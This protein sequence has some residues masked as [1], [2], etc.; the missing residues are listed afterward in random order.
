[1]PLPYVQDEVPDQEAAGI[2]SCFG[3][4][5]GRGSLDTPGTTQSPA[6]S[7]LSSASPSEGALS[8]YCRRQ[9]RS[10][11]VDSGADVSVFPATP[12][13][14]RKAPTVNLLAANGSSIRTY[15]K[16]SIALSFPGLRVVHVF[17]LAAVRRPILGTDFFRAQDL[18]ID[19]T[20]RRLFR[21]AEC[22][23]AAVEVRARPAQFAGGLCGLRRPP[24]STCSP[25]SSPSRTFSP[26]T[27][28]SASSLRVAVQ[29]LFA[30]FPAV[31]SAPVYDSTP[32]KHGIFHTVPTS[33][34]PVYALSLIHI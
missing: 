11:L 22:S 16:K 19:I 7:T 14:R 31:T 13:Q 27:P 30:E 9:R 4:R 12:A 5:Q 15:G 25:S 24:T 6:I 32:P 33:G 34:P 26:L 23:P 20:G 3:K 29:E 21:P 18:V 17:L 8:V 28:T 1:M 2:F 10:F